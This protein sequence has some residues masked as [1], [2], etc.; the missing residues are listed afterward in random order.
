[1][2]LL[3]Q[4]GATQIIDEGAGEPTLLLHGVP[5]SG[6]MWRGV[7]A[8]LAP[9]FR[10]IAPDLPGMGRSATPAGFDYSLDSMADWV[11][12]VVTSLSI[13]KPLNLVVHDFGGQF[14]LAWAVKHPQKVRRLAIFSTNFFSSYRWHP[15]AQLWRTPLLGELSLALT[16][17]GMWRT[18][19]K[20]FAPSIAAEQIDQTYDLSIANPQVRR[21]ILRMYRATN[22]ENFRGWEDR[23]LELTSH[24]P[25]YV[26]WGDRDPFAPISQAERFGG[27]VEHF[28]DY[29]HWLPAEAPTLIGQRLLAF[30]QR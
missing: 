15:T 24:T 6:E 20:K 18:Q 4:N 7:I 11:D 23:M 13:D 30:F 19:M 14:G 12:G 25:T 9:R 22:S 16:S 5:D 28:A 27:T 29:G 1:M 10:C 21:T 8:Q 17:R 3:I 2:T 26:L